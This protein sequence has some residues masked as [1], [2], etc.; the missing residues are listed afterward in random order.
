[1]ALKV[2]SGCCSVGEKWLSNHTKPIEAS[3][4]KRG[5]ADDR[6]NDALDE[7]LDKDIRESSP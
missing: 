3:R 5:A 6:D 1:M 4:L 7:D 2:I